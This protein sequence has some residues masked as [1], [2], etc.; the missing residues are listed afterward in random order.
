MKKTLIPEIPFALPSSIAKIA[1]AATVYDS[2]CSPEARVYYLSGGEGYYLKR[3]AGRSLS[4]E[5]EMTRYFHSLGLGTEVIDYVSSDDC[6][7]LLS[8]AVRGEDCTEAIYTRDPKRL[9]DTT[10]TLLRALHETDFSSCPFKDKMNE[11]ISIAERNYLTDNYDKT[12]FPDNFGYRTADE[13][14]GVLREGKH[15]LKSDTLL[16]GDYCLPNIILRDWKLG[17]FI[18]VDHGGVG[19]RHIDL[20]WGAWS[21]QFNLGT[22]KYRERFF[23]VYGRD[24]VD[25]DILRI[26]AAAEVFG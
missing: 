14:I 4:R 10:A 9:C 8:L 22:D 3:S 21:L 5:A 19:D 26:V 1:A 23:D 7:W 20:F 25:R 6:D 15:L 12:H 11:Y 2:S 13:A 17:A 18:D 24:R 16:H